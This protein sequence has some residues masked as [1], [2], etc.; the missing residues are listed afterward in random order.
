MKKL[1]SSGVMEP[2]PAFGAQYNG[3][4]ITGLFQQVLQVNAQLRFRP[5][6]S[7]NGIAFTFLCSH[8]KIQEA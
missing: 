8:D 5:C 4:F 3:G 7:M 6:T 1:S 2:A